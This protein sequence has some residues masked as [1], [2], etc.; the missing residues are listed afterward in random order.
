MLAASTRAWLRSS[1][2]RMRPRLTSSKPI[3]RVASCPASQQRCHER[4]TGLGISPS[5]TRP[6][7]KY[8]LRAP[9]LRSARTRSHPLIITPLSIIWTLV[10]RLLVAA[11]ALIDRLRV[12]STTVFVTSSQ[13]AIASIAHAIAL[14]TCLAVEAC[15]L[16]WTFGGRAR[17]RTSR[18]Q[19]R[20][21]GE[22]TAEKST[23]S[24]G[25]VGTRRGA[26]VYPSR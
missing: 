14:G 19:R 18:Q 21:G 4:N 1:I 10:A 13:A 15:R 8:C 16:R 7:S 20:A 6:S 23:G 22:H 24:D 25:C 3:G 26:V 11:S 12:L 9:R 2:S 17:I 5:G